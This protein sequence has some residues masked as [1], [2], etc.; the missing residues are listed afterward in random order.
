MCSGEDDQGIA[1]AA[2][3]MG[4]TA[5]PLTVAALAGV[6]QDIAAAPAVLARGAAKQEEE[7]EECGGGARENSSSNSRAGSK[8]LLR[9]CRGIRGSRRVTWAKDVAKS[10]GA[11][12]RAIKFLEASEGRGYKDSASSLP[13]PQM[14]NDLF[15]LGEG[16]SDVDGGGGDSDD[17]VAAAAGGLGGSNQDC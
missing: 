12:L 8:E 17:G 7:K 2:E 3:S 4:E 10:L 9:L 13:A 11:A 16:G 1:T 6:L 14:G 5:A 15:W